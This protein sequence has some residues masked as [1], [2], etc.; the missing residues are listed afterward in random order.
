[1]IFD[2]TVDNLCIMLWDSGSSLNLV[3][4]LLQ[5]RLLGEASHYY[6][7]DVEVQVPYLL[8]LILE[9]VGSSLLG[10]TVLLPYLVPTDIHWGWPCYRWVMVKALTL[11][12]AFS[13][14]REEPQYC[15]MKIDMQAPHMVS[16]HMVGVGL[17]ISWHTWMFWPPTWLSLSPTWKVC[18][19]PHCSLLNAE[20]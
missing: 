13:E 11:H 2:W 17:I 3:L 16:T 1:M 8:P 15:W 14:T 5:Q 7:A 19:V 18:W 12:S 9:W 10:M 20:V 4:T 6:Q